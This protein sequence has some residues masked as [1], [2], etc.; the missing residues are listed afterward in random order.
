MRKLIL[1]L[2]IIFCLPIGMT[3]DEGM[4]LPSQ[5]KQ[6]M[7]YEQMKE[8]G[9]EL[10]PEDIY[11]INNASIKDAIVRSTAAAAPARSSLPKG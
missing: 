10:S 11:D 6:L 5:I 4:W 7:L 2:T 3:A 8:L 1:S 9:L